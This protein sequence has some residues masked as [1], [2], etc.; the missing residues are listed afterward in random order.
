MRKEECKIE[1]KDLGNGKMKLEVF[2]SLQNLMVGLSSI[3]KGL[4]EHGIDKKLI[5][6]AVKSGLMTDEELK[7]D[8]LDKLDKIK[9]LLKGFMGEE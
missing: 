6:S 4:K 9:D 2:G 3:V 8:T 5:E 1:F 7:K